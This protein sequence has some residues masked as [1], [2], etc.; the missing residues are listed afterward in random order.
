MPVDKLML[1]EINVKY[2]FK[3]SKSQCF[4]KRILSAFIMANKV[5]ARFKMIREESLW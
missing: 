5:L 4:T 1:V 2:S 3:I